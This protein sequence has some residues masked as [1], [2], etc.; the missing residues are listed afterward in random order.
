MLRMVWSGTLLMALSLLQLVLFESGRKQRVAIV[1]GMAGA[2]LACWGILSA[3]SEDE[4]SEGKGEGKG[5]PKTETRT[6]TD[7]AHRQYR[8]P[9]RYGKAELQ[10]LRDRPMGADRERAFSRSVKGRVHMHGMRHIG[11]GCPL[12][13]S[14]TSWEADGESN[15]P[16]SLTPDR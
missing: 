2:G 10:R 14:I 12:R 8:T 15:S 5:K 16:G 4:T 11:G 3:R 9:Q 6:R 1:Y 13:R 7:Y